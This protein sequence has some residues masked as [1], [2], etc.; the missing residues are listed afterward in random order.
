MSIDPYFGLSIDPY[1][2]LTPILLW[3]PFRQGGASV[4][5]GKFKLV[6]RFEPLPELPDLVELYD[7]EETSGSAHPAPDRAQ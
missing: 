1:F 7:L 4:R 6:K 5:S 3:F 2:G